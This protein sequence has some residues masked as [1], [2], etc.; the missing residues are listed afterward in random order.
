MKYQTAKLLMLAG[1]ALRMGYGAGSFSTPAWMVSSE[2]APD[3]HD[4][5]E[6]RL[7]LRAFG[8][9]QLVT[10]AFALAALRRPR[11]LRS[12]AALG[13]A[14]D[15]FDVASAVLELRARGTPD[16]AT[17]GGIAL[18]GGGVL[19]FGTALRALSR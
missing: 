3:T 13:L 1:T 14:I 16:R 12:A 9:H 7:L 8:G 17:V 4:L 10:G 2:L 11:L 18:S 6:P 15:A 5:P 19:I